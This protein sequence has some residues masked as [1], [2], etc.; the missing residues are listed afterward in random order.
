MS[1]GGD[2]DTLAGSTPTITGATT[3]LPEL[4]ANRYRI[5]RWLGGG[6]MGRVYE[7]IDTELN[8]RVALKVL[9]AGLTDDA[10]ERFRREVRLTRRVQHRNVARMFDIGD[11]EGD[12]FLTMELVEGDSLSKELGAPM[13]WRRLQSLAIQICEGL[14]AAHDLGIVHRDLKPDNI[15]IERANDR[16]V[17]TD[18][19]IA[20]SMDDAGVTQEGAVV[21]TPRY[22]APE[23]L[24]GRAIDKRADIFAL[25][26]MLY[27]LSTGSRPWPGDNAISIAVAQATQPLSPLRYSSLPNGFTA[28]VTR[29][30]EIEPARRPQNAGEILATLRSPDA[31]IEK[32]DAPATVPSRPLMPP[33]TMPTMTQ[34]PSTLAVLPLAC[35]AADEYLADGL[36][37]D[38]TDILSTTPNL[39]VRPAGLVRSQSE[40]D[41]RAVGKKL[42]VDHVVAGSLRRT[43]AS[44]I[45]ISARLI[46]VADGFQI[47]AKRHECTEADL[48][49]TSEVLAREIASALSTRA[50]ASTRPTDPRSVDLYLRARAELRRFWGSHAQS[51]ADL[52]DQ[53]HALSPTSAPIAGARALATVQ[54]WVLQSEPSLY[55]RARRALEQ[56]LT[57]GHAE[58][59]LASAAFKLNTGDPTNAVKD[60]AIAL[61]RAPMLAQAHEMTARLLVEL[62]SLSEARQHYETAIALDPTRTPVISMELARLD[63]LEGWWERA[64]RRIEALLE[65]P[66]RSLVQLASVF[67]S[68]LAGWRG[69]RDAMLLAAQR[70]APRMG[71]SAS[72]LV[73]FLSHTTLANKFEASTW[74]SFLADF[75]GAARPARGQLMG[76]QLLSEISIVFGH[77]DFA[78]ATLEE[79]DHRN[80]LDVVI[81]EKCPLYDRI[82]ADP[83]FQRVRENVAERAKNVLMAFRSTAS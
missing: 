56:A 66:D 57:T 39:R 47:W 73:D 72:K 53:A 10:L 49:A 71:T 41:P 38:L 6:G 51:A 2:D 13:G 70:F 60:L 16:A 68:R 75:G 63:A 18:F 82:R 17:I 42:D 69:D 54:A 26:V 65:D 67:Q 19:G 78:L 24:S 21:G 83:R 28:L 50:T 62:D 25:G 59:Y 11:H 37:E 23:Q 8:E 9:R 29:C 22:M 4:V 27:E 76:L 32:T 3:D 77:T 1:V 43:P 52:L 80:F 20:R 35:A 46:S 30:L 81:L 55:D 34:N 79:A 5:V 40:P 44:T 7:A 48:L 15:L 33:A 45:R 36:H 14:E 64:D 31:M 12:R 61:V 58:A 74:H